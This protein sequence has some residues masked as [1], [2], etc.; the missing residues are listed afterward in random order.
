MLQDD[1]DFTPLHEGQLDRDK[2]HIPV[3]TA[4]GGPENT[5][6]E[7]AEAQPIP[8]V[9]QPEQIQ[10]EAAEWQDK[11]TRLYA[12]LENSKRRLARLYANQAEQ[13]KEHLLRDMLPLADNLER[14]LANASGV[15][16]A[17]ELRQG[18]ALTLKAFVDAL[19]KHGVRPIQAQGQP[20][21][22][23][24]HEAAGAVLRP[25]LPPGTVIRVEQ[26]G[27]TVGDK[28]L[29]PARVLVAAG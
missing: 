12:E 6:I 16:A 11:Y 3:R 1:R 7:E 23:E 27:Y 5:V 18:V 21:D 26:E 24:L 28:L 10:A 4:G 20:F 29:R 8:V 22:P 15:E 9:E 2:T 13:D 25:A 14:A 19:A 17:G